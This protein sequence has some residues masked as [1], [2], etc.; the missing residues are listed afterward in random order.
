[1]FK[2]T[3]LA[4]VAFAAI[5][6]S[7]EAFSTS[8]RRAFIGKLGTT[9]SV[10]A[11]ATTINPSNANAVG[12][13]G[14]KEAIDATH[15]G[16]DLNGSQATVASSLL[17]KMGVQDITADKGSQYSTTNKGPVKSTSYTKK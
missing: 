6:A 14:G 10:A 17:D 1:M 11:I 8:S 2:S 9:A 13:R 4:F 7:S 5:T 15:N 12:K 3:R 16:T